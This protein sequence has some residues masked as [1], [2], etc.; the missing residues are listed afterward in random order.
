MERF[1]MNKE[2]LIEIMDVFN[3]SQH[4]VANLTGFSQN[5]ISMLLTEK[6]PFSKNAKEQ[7]E[8]MFGELLEN[9]KNL[10]KKYK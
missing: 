3:L 9:V 4:D 6:K 5:Y 1:T 10:E 2:K 8:N 7:L